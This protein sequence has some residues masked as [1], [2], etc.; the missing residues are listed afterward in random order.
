M[1]GMQNEDAINSAREHVIDFVLF[2]RNRKHHAHEVGRIGQV[3]ARIYIGFADRILVGHGHK[4]RHL[5]DQLNSGHSA[6]LRIKQ[7]AALGIERRHGTDQ[8]GQYGHRM[9]IT[10]ESLQEKMH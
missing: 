2:A 10:T 8:T 4:S 9:S 5:A 3:I 1:I 6:L 7:V